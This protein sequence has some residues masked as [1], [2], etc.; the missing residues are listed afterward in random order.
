LPVIEQD[1]SVVGMVTDSDLLKLLV[2]S[3][4]QIEEHNEAAG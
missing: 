2:R 3:L 4:R 1:G